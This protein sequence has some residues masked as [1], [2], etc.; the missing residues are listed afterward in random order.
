[1]ELTKKA[2]VWLD[3][4]QVWCK[5]GMNQVEYCTTYG[6]HEKTFSN[7][8]T[9]L[10]KHLPDLPKKTRATIVPAAPRNPFLE[11]R[12]DDLA[13]MTEPSAK[14]QVASFDVSNAAPAIQLH[15]GTKYSISIN[16]NF[17]LATLQR[18]LS[19]LPE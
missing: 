16:A 17:D 3:H 9:K 12:I 7:W 14:A 6:L 1:M 11:V 19:A 2:E 15:I 10:H 13:E 18:L 4:M 5:S 8:K